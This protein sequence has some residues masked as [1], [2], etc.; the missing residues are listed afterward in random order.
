MQSSYNCSRHG[1]WLQNNMTRVAVG[2]A[3]TKVMMFS[4]SVAWKLNLPL[5]AGQPTNS[6][7]FDCWEGEEKRGGVQRKTKKVH[8]LLPVGGSK[9]WADSSSLLTGDDH[10]VNYCM[11][12]YHSETY[13][14]AKL[15]RE[16]KR[17]KFFSCAICKLDKTWEKVEKSKSA[18]CR[19][20]QACHAGQKLSSTVNRV[21][22]VYV[23]STEAFMR[24]MR[25]I[26]V[27]WVL[28]KS[29]LNTE[30]VWPGWSSDAEETDVP[31][32]IFHATVHHARHE[33]SS[34]ML[35]GMVAGTCPSRR[36]RTTFL[37]LADLATSSRR[38]RSSTGWSGKHV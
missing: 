37:A 22:Y 17:L 19:A 15:N 1:C 35:A 21:T 23:T 16:Q 3:A 13:T 7:G 10:G 6:P 8:R 18:V 34:L 2:V 25:H 36:F 38:Q 5:W 20:N 14:A 26:L 24:A 33:T 4:P 28:R 11:L 27:C 30:Y 12:R 31:V 32:A 29:L 9:W